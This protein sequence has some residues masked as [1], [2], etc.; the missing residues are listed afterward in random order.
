MATR[1]RKASS[2][3]RGKYQEPP[4]L[5]PIPFEEAVRDVL[6]VKPE[7]KAKPRRGRKK[8]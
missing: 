2:T 1:R 7:P 4:S 8:A 3:K 6:A 5:N